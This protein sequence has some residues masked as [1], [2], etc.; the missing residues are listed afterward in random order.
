MTSSRRQF[1]QVAGFSIATLAT[2]RLPAWLDG[3]RDADLPALGMRLRIR[4]PWRF[5]AGLELER[6]RAEVV[7]P[8]GDAAKEQVKAMAGRPLLVAAREPYP[9]PGPTLVVWRQL[10]EDHHHA[11][12][13][14]ETFAAIHEFTYRQYAPYLRDYALLEPGSAVSFARRP[15]SRVVVGFRDESIRGTSWPVRLE[16]H[17]L[18]W[19][20]SWLTFNFLDLADGWAPRARED[21]RAIEDSIKLYA[22][23][24]AV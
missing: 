8:G 24:G 9:D 1:L 6:I 12:D 20:H 17:M 13:E 5:I 16:S 23:D 11:P 4:E 21:F 10:A 7:L 18:R 14:N 19:E 22:P 3:R 2:P 15:A